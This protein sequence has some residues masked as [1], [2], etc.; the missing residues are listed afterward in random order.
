MERPSREAG[1]RRSELE[2]L[3]GC[4][5]DSQGLLQ[6]FLD[7]TDMVDYNIDL[8]NHNDMCHSFFCL[9]KIN[10]TIGF[11]FDASD[12][13][14]PTYPSATGRGSSQD[15]VLFQKLVLG[16]HLARFL[17]YELENEKG[18]TATIGISTN[19]ILA[20]LVGNVNKPK[21]QTT[22]LPP[23]NTD[24]DSESNVTAFM[25]AHDVG[26]IPGIGF[27][28]SQKIRAHILGRQPAFEEGLVYGGTK[29]DVTVRD[30]RTFPG[31]GPEMLEGVLSGRGSQKG[32]G[33]KIWS[34]IHG[35]DDTEV[36]Q[37]KKVPSQISIED[38]YIRL[39]TWEEV[40][41]ELS[42][43]SVSLI[44]R[45][46]LDLMEDDEGSESSD[47]GPARRWLAHPRTLRLTTR[48]RPPC[49]PDGTRSRSFNRISRSI[50]MPSFIFNLTEN[51]LS[52]AE[53][54]VQDALIPI[55]KKLHPERSAWN[56]SLV[57]IAVSNMAETAADNKDSEGRDISRMFRKQDDVL[58]Q[59]KVADVDIA[60][61]LPEQES[62]GR[63][64]DSGDLG[65]HF[66]ATKIGASWESDEE[67]GDVMHLCQ[68]CGVSV[69]SFA[70]AAHRR[71]HDMP[72][73]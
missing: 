14:G 9:S 43:L 60:P 2:S 20:K 53:R 73:E 44:R 45:M 70:S 39:D 56:L 27:K 64:E 4:T 50:P 71:F 1:F 65:A 17:R 13:F 29:E 58:K 47:K 33:G 12:I 68:Q 7:C 52:L 21:S 36:S 54:L 6:V 46:H 25:D 28:L 8:L 3:I 63:V 57:N 34:L 66:P 55:F 22:L 38:S 19:K 51:I 41:K 23:Y 18:Y 30:V 61:D 37:T 31:M 40:K 10:P 24:L 49:N 16:S 32:I 42:T 5:I 62:D 26:K 15:N 72:D 67:A 59:W 48:P 35:V 69:P 11:E